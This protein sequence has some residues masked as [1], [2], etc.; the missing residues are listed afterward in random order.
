MCALHATIT[1]HKRGKKKR[2]IDLILFLKEKVNWIFPFNRNLW[3]DT[4]NF[5]W[6]SER[7][8]EEGG[9]KVCFTYLGSD[10]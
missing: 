7:E 3:F 4:L 8:R 10:G 1:Y 9:V 6:A 2:W 5:L